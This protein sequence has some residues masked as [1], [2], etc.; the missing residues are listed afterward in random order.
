M[1]KLITAISMIKMEID[2]LIFERMAA[3][4]VISESERRFGQ[5]VEHAQAGIFTLEYP[6]GKISHA[7]DAFLHI[8]G[9]ERE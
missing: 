6:S 2:M 8:L 9:R 5:L 3:E 1:G 7:N 4:K